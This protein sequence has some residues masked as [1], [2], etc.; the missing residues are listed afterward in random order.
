MTSLTK[1]A[2]PCPVCE[3]PVNAPADTLTG[4]ILSCDDC[5][6][7]LEVTGLEPF[8]VAEAPE[9]EEDWGE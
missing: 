2:A 7:E 9:V 3:A 5:A 1:Q 6:A 4:E 8:A